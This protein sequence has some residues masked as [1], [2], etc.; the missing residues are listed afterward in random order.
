M[1]RKAEIVIVSIFGGLI[2]ILVG[3]AGHMLGGW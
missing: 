2:A 3:S 1:I